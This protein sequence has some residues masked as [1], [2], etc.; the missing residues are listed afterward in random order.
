MRAA[1]RRFWVYRWLECT[2]R[3]KRKF[4]W[5]DGCYRWQDHRDGVDGL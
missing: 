3:L 4:G 2:L 5:R 1:L